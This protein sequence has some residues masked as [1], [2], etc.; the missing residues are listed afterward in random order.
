MQN[1]SISVLSLM[2]ALIAAAA[3][4]PHASA[5]TTSASEPFWRCSSGYTFETSGSAVHCK[6]PLWTETKAYMN[7]AIGLTL[8]YDQVGNTDMCTGV[9][10]LG[11]VSIEPAC[12]PTDVLAGYTKRIVDGKDFCGKTHPAEIVAPSVVISL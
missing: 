3:F 11:A 5:R 8:K 7:C 1:R 2:V 10:P 12:N 4:A 6:K 9:T